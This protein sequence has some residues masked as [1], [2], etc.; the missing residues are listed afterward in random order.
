MAQQDQDTKRRRVRR[1]RLDSANMVVT[2]GAGAQEQRYACTTLPQPV[3]TYLTLLGLKQA[4]LM[5]HD[6]NVA[7]QALRAGTVPQEK[8]PAPPRKS[9]WREAIAYALAASKVAAS[10][11]KG[12]KKAVIEQMIQIELPEMTERA[13]A[14]SKEVVRK[15]GERADVQDV[16]RRLYGTKPSDAQISLWALAGFEEPMSLSEEKYDGPQEQAA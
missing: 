2:L 5:K 14:L 7:Y 15:L 9:R 6:A 1:G 3:Q 10:A 12:T 11:P 4:L 16:Y 8:P 13:G